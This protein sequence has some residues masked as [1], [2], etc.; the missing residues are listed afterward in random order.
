MLSK[1]FMMLCTLT[2]VQ[3]QQ[4]F[5]G[6][7]AGTGGATEFTQW[8]NY[9]QL[10]GSG[11]L[12]AQMV[13]NQITAQI[14]RA[15]EL[16]NSYQNLANAPAAVIA[17]TIAPYQNMVASSQQL[18]NSVNGIYS[19]YNQA[20]QMV[21][22]RT[23][24]AQALGANP[25]QYLN[26][27]A[28]LAVQKGG[29]YQAAYQRDTQTLQDVVTKS[30]ALQNM[31]SNIPSTGTVQ[32]LDKLNATTAM[33]AGE[34]I[35]LNKQLALASIA[36]GQENLDQIRQSTTQAAAAQKYSQELLDAQQKALQAAQQPSGYS[37]QQIRENAYKSLG[38]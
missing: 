29:I 10:V 18:L 14:A 36:K 32:G 6:S 21:Q 20:A 35:A 22:T 4:A 13:A 17:Q 3:T 2:F 33:V 5:A 38:L 16:V 8:L 34:T 15:Q 30:Q 25:Q 26:L 19:S 1:F 23:A 28:Q 9:G 12:Q 27:E 37:Q 24:E 31:T 11:V 7:V